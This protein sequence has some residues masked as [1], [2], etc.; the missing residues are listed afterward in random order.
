MMADAL[1]LQGAGTTDFAVYNPRYVS[2]EDKERLLEKILADYALENEGNR[3]VRG[4]P[5]S[6]I[7]AVLASRY[8]IK[9]ESAGVFFR[10]QI[11]NYELAGGTRNKTILFNSRKE[12]KKES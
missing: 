10:N 8:G 9:T 5:F 1:K 2:T 4:M 3:L 6:T 11:K 12:L 7:K